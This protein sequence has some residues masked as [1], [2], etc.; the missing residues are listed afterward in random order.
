MVAFGTSAPELV[1]NIVGALEGQTELAFGNI[2]GSNLANIG[3]VL[4]VTAMMTPMKLQGFT[5]DLMQRQQV[6][7]FRE[8]RA[9]DPACAALDVARAEHGG[10]ERGRAVRDAVRDVLAE[11]ARRRREVQ[12]DAAPADVRGELVEEM[13]R[14]LGDRLAVGGHRRDPEPD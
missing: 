2:T 5:S 8:I 6:L 11:R 12:R 13:P 3:L 14:L 4:G 1:I 9:V 10:G 7:E